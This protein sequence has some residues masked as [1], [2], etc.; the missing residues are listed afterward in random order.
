MY[1][2][3]GQGNWQGAVRSQHASGA[4]IALCD[5]SVRYVSDWI[6]TTGSYATFWDR[7]ICSADGFTIDASKW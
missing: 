7:L 2:C 6:E 1:C 4:F 3:G 5:G